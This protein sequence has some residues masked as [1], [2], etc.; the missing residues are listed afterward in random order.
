MLKVNLL[1]SG[2]R[3][4]IFKTR[5]L[6]NVISD[7]IPFC[8]FYEQYFIDRQNRFDYPPFTKINDYQRNPI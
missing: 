8:S 6:F 3:F 1:R 5:H 2:S 7:N 4:L